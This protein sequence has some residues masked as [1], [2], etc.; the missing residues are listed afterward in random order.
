MNNNR[1]NNEASSGRHAAPSNDQ[2]GRLNVDSSSYGAHGAQTSQGAGSVGAS[3]GGSYNDGQSIGQGTAAHSANV[4]SGNDVGYGN[5]S[6]VS[7][8]GY[9]NAGY[10]NGNGAYNGNASYGN[11][12]PNNNYNASGYNNGYNNSY[13][14]DYGAY[15]RYQGRP[16]SGY[17]PAE[18]GHKKTSPAKVAGIFIFVIIL[19][20]LVAYV[21]GAFYFDEHL[22]P[23]TTIGDID[24]SLMSLSDAEDAIEDVVD[25]YTLTIEG[26]DFTLELS[27]DDASIVVEADEIV[28][29]IDAERNNWAWI[30]E[31]FE[32]HDES[33]AL[34]AANEGTGLEE[35]VTA[36]VEEYNESATQPTDATIVYNDSTG[37]FDVVAESIG[38][39]LDAEAVVAL[40][41]EA[42][43]DLSETCELSDSELLQPSVISSD[44]RVT[45]ALETANT[46]LTADLW[47]AFKG[48]IIATISGSDVADLVS[49]D[50]DYN[51]TIDEDYLTTFAEELDE[52]YTTVGTARTY[53]RADGKEIEVEG[54][55]W[56]WNI[57][58][59]GLVDTIVENLTAGTVGT[60]EIPC[61]MYGDVFT[62]L[63]ER[64][65][66]ARYIDIDLTEQHVYFYDENG[67]LIWESDCVTGTPDGEHDTP[68][69]VYYITAKS[70]PETLT[71][72]DEDGEID[73][74]T[75]VTYWMAFVEN[76]IGLH[77][78]T[79]Q[80]EFGGTR[81][82]DGYGSHGCVNLPLD[83]AA[84][85]Y[86][87]VEVGDVVVV[88]W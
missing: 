48:T 62:A 59:D 86:E 88:H 55:S 41:E 60:V 82:I 20:L 81:Y 46:L 73:Y 47:L 79:W 72:Y 49:L 16:M 57:Y 74:E 83:A 35:A 21:V 28:E 56:G 87:L 17:V 4:G 34:V 22:Y 26:D 61:T 64:D 3:Q 44:E 7:N 12:G 37:S 39:A 18:A 24:V 80:T 14:S 85:L 58:V 30:V 69:G 43:A 25:D 1:S 36:A 19:L 51:V 31:V 2:S 65:W 68:E 38:T 53:T 70:S 13:N 29:E 33:D 6:Y 5:G 9:N 66:G 67:D 23:N 32:D 10:G 15:S 75:E 11:G 40:A 8:G 78:A 50:S 45:T 76:S 27:A 71:A 77:D 63:G 54:G 42:L 52:E 84:E